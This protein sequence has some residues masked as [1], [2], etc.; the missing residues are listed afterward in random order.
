MRVAAA[1]GLIACGVVVA[2]AVPGDEDRGPVTRHALWKIEGGRKPVYLLGSIHVLRRQNY[3]LERPIE[4]AFDE[5]HVVAFELD[6]DEARKAAAQ[7]RKAVARVVKPPTLRNQV[8]PATYQS[9]VR[10]LE[11]AGYPGT[12]F[13]QLPA[14]FVA[15]AL[16]Q[17][18]LAKLGFDPQWG[19]DAYFYRR[20]QKYGKTIVA[21]ETV[22]QQ[23]ETLEE[24]SERGSDELVQAALQDVGAL[25]TRLRDLIRAWKGG[26][27][28]RLTTLVNGS[29]E[30]RPEV[31]QR[32]L[33]ERNA[34]WLPQIEAL[35]AGDVPALVIVGTGHLVGSESVIAM[36]EAKGHVVRQQ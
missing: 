27:I 21:L 14:P 13:D 16:V 30:A 15:N 10:Y 2:L 18:E 31:Y 9:V 28:E 34:R 17:M 4:E 33:V 12:V 5:A 7:P 36:L 25:R 19:V 11:D 29:F 35:M 20:A 22:E 26:E 24:L 23:V 32:V 6:L 1:I 3:P 8:S